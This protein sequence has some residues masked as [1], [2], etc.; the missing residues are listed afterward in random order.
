MS[1]NFAAQL[2]RIQE[3]LRTKGPQHA[4]GPKR[5]TLSDQ[6]DKHG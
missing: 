3:L 4:S 6:E 5:P 2:A 1:D